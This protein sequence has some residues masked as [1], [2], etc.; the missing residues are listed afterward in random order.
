MTRARFRLAAPSAIAGCLLAFAAA[1]PASADQS[2]APA[3]PSRP[4]V[5][6]VL[7]GG[8]AKGGA[9]VGVLKV[10]EEMHVPIDCIAG[11]SMGALVGGGYASGIP[12]AGLEKFVTGIDWKTVVGGV[13]RRDLQTIE[14]KRAGVTYSNDIEMG[15]KHK[16]VL[17][18]GGIVNT[19]SIEDL[20]RTYVARSRAQTDFDKLPI[21][22]RAVATDMV[23]GKMVVLDSGDLA[24]AMRASMAI[25]GA[26]APVVTDKYILSDGGMVRNIPVDIA[27]N[28]CADVVIVVNLVEEEVKREQLQ[29]A[30]QLVLRS[31]DVGIMANENLQLES[32]TERDVR[33][34][35][36][37]GDITTAD[38]ERIPD[39]IPLG[40]AATRA[41]AS[42]L[43]VLAVPEAQY[44]AWRTG[45]TEGQNIDARV[46]DVQY[47]G[48]ERVNPQYLEQRAQLR[49]GDNIDTAKISAEAT[50][51]SALQEFESVEYRLTG[52]PG[53]PTLE[54][55]PKEKAYGPNYLK[56]DLGLYGSEGGD[57]GFVVYGKH[58]RTWLN[59]L[60]AEWRNEVQLG[61]FNNISTSLYQPLDIAQRFFV[62]PQA[63]WTRSWED[64]F[65]DNDRLARYK[66]SDWG[67]R[68]DVGANL[69]DDAQVRVGYLYTRRKAEVET[70]SLIL[71]ETDRT[72][73]GMTVTATFDSRDTAFNPTRGV[74]AALEYAYVD[75]SLGGDLNWERL[76]LGLGLALPVRSDV[77][78]LTLAGGTDLN[79]SLPRDRYFMLGG[80]GSFPGYELGELRLTDYW[81][82]SGSYLWKIKDIMRIRGQALY[83]G[84]RLEAGETFGRL[85]STVLPGFDENEM[86]YGG[87]L[88]LTGRTQIGPLTVGLGMTSN[89][90][91]SLWIAVGRPVGNGTIL[92]RGIF[93]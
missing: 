1:C 66:F 64:I 88:Y 54:W 79:S 47:K 50:R 2:L 23:S 43:A 57:L 30:T 14:Q 42:K 17:L 91:W 87:S 7:A 40:E 13:G 49:P 78:W 6:L 83:A 45:V 77:V 31:S 62:E 35:V 68:V 75:D 55:W 84:L 34:D 67:G 69:S 39:T 15:L 38:F 56:F 20:L 73:A 28:L 19:S 58:A 65:I 70:G 11:T 92:E 37:M 18:P 22:Y 85:E 44:V 86:L 76:E 53:N 59:S 10:L 80:P 36:L 32:L 5:G 9:H 63:F 72:D 33:I 27:R 16:Q 51:M 26:F 3:A 60:G 81:T 90:S 21:P 89:D 48:L 25:P 71:P 46:A 29:T 41:M 8:G 52:D 93:R 24:T 74:A 82:A 12:A 61:Y 4:R